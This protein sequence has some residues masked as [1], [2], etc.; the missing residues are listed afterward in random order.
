[1]TIEFGQ[2][3]FLREIY[4]RTTCNHGLNDSFCRMLIEYMMPWHLGDKLTGRGLYFSMLI[5]FKKGKT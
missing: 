2:S 4:F 1:M 3:E 5:P